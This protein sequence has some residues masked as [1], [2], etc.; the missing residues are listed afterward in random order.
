MRYSGGPTS[1]S[2]FMGMKRTRHAPGNVAPGYGKAWF[3]IGC[4]PGR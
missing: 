4:R 3:G 1:V 2:A